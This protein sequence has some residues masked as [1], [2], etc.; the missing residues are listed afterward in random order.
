MFLG[1][2]EIHSTI[3]F[4]NKEFASMKTKACTAILALFLI[5]MATPWSMK[6]RIAGPTALGTY[7]FELGDGYTKQVDFEARTSEEGAATGQMTFKDPAGATDQDPDEPSDRSEEKP[8]EFY[9]TADLSTLTIEKNRALMAGIVRESSLKS[10][11]G[12]FVQLV[13]EDNGALGDEPDRF[14]WRLCQPEPGGWTPVDAEDP[15]DEGASMKWWATDAE[16]TDDHG[17]A[18]A[19]INPGN[20]RGCPTFSLS[21]YRFPNVKG[22]GEI[23]ILP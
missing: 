4:T 9:M 11:V 15:K 16:L 1:T 12:K 6:A 22:E 19:N 7:R 3:D 17:V 2:P 14:T 21:T 18:S 10:Y 5:S 20:S 8:S 13:V 23:Q